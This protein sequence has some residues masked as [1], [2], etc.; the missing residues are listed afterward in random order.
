MTGYEI[1]KKALQRL[2]IKN[3]NNSLNLRAVEYINQI[4]ADLNGGAIENLSDTLESSPELCEAITVGL[5]MLF[6]LTIGDTAANKIY[7]DL[8]NAKR[9]KLLSNSDTVTDKLP[10]GDSI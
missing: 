9:A 4:S 3:E 1:L 6:S 2:G 10:K 5:V 7:T 8:Y